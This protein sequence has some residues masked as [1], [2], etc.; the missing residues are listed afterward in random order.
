MVNDS[1]TSFDHNN[2]K[3]SN[4]SIN[5]NNPNYTQSTLYQQQQQY[6][7]QQYTQQQYTQQQYPQQQNI[8]SNNSFLNNTSAIYPTQS[9][10]TIKQPGNQSFYD[11]GLL[12][13]I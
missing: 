1:R 12:D 13:L 5:I 2:N 6:T 9:K 11:D 10:V 7:Q 3:K 4:V 8:K